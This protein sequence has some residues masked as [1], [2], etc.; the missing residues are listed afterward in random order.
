MAQ[1]LIDRYRGDTTELGCWQSKLKAHNRSGSRIILK[2]LPVRPSLHQVALI[3]AN[4]LD[5]LKKLWV[6][7][8]TMQ[9]HS[10][11]TISCASILNI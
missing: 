6:R 7:G 1:E 2:K 9:S 11:A 5:E 3:A 4:R 10:S 8:V